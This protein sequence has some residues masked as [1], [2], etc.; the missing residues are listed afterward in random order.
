M[1]E[2]GRPREV[3]PTL[4]VALVRCTLAVCLSRSRR[5][6]AGYSCPSSP[7][8]HLGLASHRVLAWVSDGAM[9]LEPTE[10]G[11]AVRQRG[12]EEVVTESNAATASPLESY[13]DPD[14]QW[15]ALSRTQERLVGE[16]KRAAAE[17]A[18][19]PAAERWVERALTSSESPMHGSTA[20]VEVDGR[21]ARVIEFKTGSVEA[22]DAQ[23]AGRYGL[24]VL[25]YVAMVRAFGKVVT[26]AEIRPI[27]PA[28]LT[29]GVSNEI[30]DVAHEVARSALREF[31]TAIETDEVATLARPSDHASECCLHTLRCPAPWEGGAAASLDRM[32]IVKGDV[33]RLQR[34]YLGSTTV[35][36]EATAWTTHGSIT[37][38]GLDERRLP[39][40]R[41]LQRGDRVRA[42]G[43]RRRPGGAVLAARPGAWVQLAR[44][45]NSEA[46]R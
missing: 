39:E 35:E 9:Q 44:V 45:G 37:L 40:F 17:L 38:T 1:A 34:S 42:S 24:E 10:L 12:H 21:A 6:T 23:P 33:L 28:R 41:E 15:P 2:D 25:L 14:N 31:N 46:F 36:V 26:T 5:R 8:A 4:V 19:A 13:F 32:Q 29:V 18:Q 11:A 16:A 27:G 22:D 7:P 3:S 20:L 30:I 43:P